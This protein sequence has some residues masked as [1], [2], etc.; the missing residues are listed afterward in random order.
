LGSYW[1]AT[2]GVAVIGL[3]LF[4]VLLMPCMWLLNRFMPLTSKEKN[5]K[6]KGLNV[7]H[8]LGQTTGIVDC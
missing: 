7:L 6:S 8:E 5:K 4:F 2:L 3:L 1:V